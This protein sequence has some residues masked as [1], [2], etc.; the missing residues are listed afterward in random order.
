MRII[1]IS[2]ISCLFLI[3][4]TVNSAEKK[5][6]TKSFAKYLC[7]DEKTILSTKSCKVF[8]GPNLNSGYSLK[9]GRYVYIVKFIDNKEYGKIAEVR[10]CSDTIQAVPFA[11]DMCLPESKKKKSRKKGWDFVFRCR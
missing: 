8:S 6:K 11:R 1:I 5:L 4:S 3:T 9:K 10:Y 2:F 7:K